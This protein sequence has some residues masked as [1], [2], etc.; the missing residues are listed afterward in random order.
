MTWRAGPD[1][2][3]AAAPFPLSSASPSSS[4]GT[5]PLRLYARY[6]D[7]PS[8]VDALKSATESPMDRADLPPKVVPLIVLVH[9]PLLAQEVAPRGSTLARGAGW[10]PAL[11]DVVLANCAA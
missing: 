10:R 4:T 9:V 8:Q 5:A 1:Y 11:V 2:F 7:M 3:P 6:T